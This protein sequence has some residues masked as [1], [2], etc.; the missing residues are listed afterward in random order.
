MR[1]THALCMRIGRYIIKQEGL[2]QNKVNSSL[3]STCNCKMD[4]N[5][6][7]VKVDIR[8]ANFTSSPSLVLKFLSWEIMHKWIPNAVELKRITTHKG[9]KSEESN[10]LFT[11]SRLGSENCS[12]DIKGHSMLTLA[13][14][15]SSRNQA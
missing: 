7:A 4:F 12:S 14:Q 9:G 8:Q 5:A 13:W 15:V 10:I 6:L 1:V 3:I 11:K 2:Y